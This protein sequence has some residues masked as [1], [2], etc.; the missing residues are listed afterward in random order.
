MAFFDQL[1]FAKPFFKEPFFGEA[2]FQGDYFADTTLAHGLTGGTTTATSVTIVCSRDITG[3]ITPADFIF[4]IDG[5]PSVIT[6]AVGT[7]KDLVL[8]VTAT[9]LV[10]EVLAVSYAGE[11]TNNIGILVNDPIVNNEV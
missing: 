4:T 6:A 3:T 7:L 10:D 5:T 11:A 9:I 8:T 1:F 2:F